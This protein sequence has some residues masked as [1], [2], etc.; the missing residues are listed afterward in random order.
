V[1]AD[2]DPELREH[3]REWRRATAK[4]NG[5]AAF[6]IMHDTSLDELCRKR[7]RSLAELLGVSGF[8]E[9]KTEMYG[10]QILDALKSF[11]DGASAQGVP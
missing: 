5:I 10:E 7:P 3:L 2:I 4:Q 9:R 6:I 11:R 8:G 1:G